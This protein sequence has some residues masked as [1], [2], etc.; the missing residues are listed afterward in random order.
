MN[1]N[2]RLFIGVFST[3]IV[4]ADRKQ[5]V[6]GDYKTVAFMSFATLALEFRHGCP[7]SLRARITEDAAKLQARRGEQFPLDH[8]GHTIQLGSTPAPLS[9]IK[10]LECCCCSGPARGRQWFN[11]D[12]GYGLCPKCATWI[13]TRETAETMRS[14]YGIAGIHYEVFE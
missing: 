14:Y 10:N 11:Q 2:E 9:P 8:C 6:S 5:I 1:E 12:T 3:G 13:R 4:Y 7:R